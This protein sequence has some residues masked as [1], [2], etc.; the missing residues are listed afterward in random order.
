[1]ILH[2]GGLVVLNPGDGDELSPQEMAAPA[3]V[4]PGLEQVELYGLAAE[5]GT[6]LWVVRWP[7]GLEV[8]L[9]AS[10]GA[11][12]DF[13]RLHQSAVELVGAF[14]LHHARPANQLPA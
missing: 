12:I 3:C 4:S 13:S 7:C 11:A 10:P 14:T 9:A 8:A 5:E 1:M 2:E 6:C